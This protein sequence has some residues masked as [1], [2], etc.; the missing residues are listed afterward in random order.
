[1]AMGVSWS[2]GG[3]EFGVASTQGLQIFSLDAA[4][5]FAPIGGMGMEV[6]PQ[7]VYR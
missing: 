1:M 6:T 3:G 5:V 2:P 7:N 4:G